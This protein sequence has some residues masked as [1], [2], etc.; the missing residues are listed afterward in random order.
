MRNKLC[1]FATLRAM[2]LVMSCAVGLR[3]ETRRRK[4]FTLI[5]LVVVIAIIALLSTLAV[6]SLRGT[7]DR[8]H[9]SQAVQ[10]V[11]LSDASA[12]R[13]ARATDQMVVA[14]I[15]RHHNRWRIGDRSFQIPTAV[16]IES[17]ALGRRAIAGSEVDIDYSRD[18]WSPTYALQLK[19]GEIEQWIVVLGA[20]GQVVSVRDRGEADALLRL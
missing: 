13:L 11:E 9:L 3:A 20:S 2:L 15:D 7:I 6:M 14:T 17:I 19:R 1:G 10:T 4:G 18:G 16:E 8:Y 5:E 12:R